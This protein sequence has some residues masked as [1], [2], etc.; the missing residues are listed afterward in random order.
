[1]TRVLV[2]YFSAS[3]VTEHAA[4]EIASAVG[5]DLFEIYPAEKYTEADLDWRDHHSRST[6]EMTDPSSRPAMVKKN[7]DLS[8][9][10]TVFV[11]FPIW[12]GVEPRIVD[13][14]FESYDFTG[15]TMIAF[16]TSGGSGMAEADR[17]VKEHCPKGNWKK[18]ALVNHGAGSW[19]SS[20][21]A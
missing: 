5:A 21:L 17:S 15:K 16:A 14:F 4:K 12:W 9:Y 1:M 8:G 13:T 18:G 2:A 10:D 7:L 6:L 19:A 20:V 3:G 11:G